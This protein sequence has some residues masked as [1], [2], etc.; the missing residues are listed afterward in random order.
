MNHFDP[1]AY[2]PVF[3]RV[4]NT[5]RRRALDAGTRDESSR[6]ELAET[7]VASAFAHAKSEFGPAQ[8]VD[9]AMA[10]CGIAG[11]WLLHD[12]LDQ[13][14][15]ISQEIDTPTGS[16]WHGIMHRREGDHS[17]AKYWFR[18][19]GRHPVYD[20]LG[21]RAGELAAE[22]G[23]SKTA[24]RLTADGGSWDP[25]AFVDLVE[26]LV[27]GGHPTVRDLCVI[28]QEAEWELLF[29]FCYRAAIGQSAA[30]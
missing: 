6:E 5:N 25:I 13:S 20:A 3:A 4:L 11:V 12:Y 29:D 24:S 9:R 19:V 23:E 27:L 2:G 26:S 8:P 17:N 18:R 28:I 15:A 7:T 16:F 21:Q 22:R 14:H 30:P 10:Q 1:N